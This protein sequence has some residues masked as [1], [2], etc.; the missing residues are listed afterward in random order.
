MPPRVVLVEEAE[1]C[2]G[3]IMDPASQR[4]SDESRLY[5]ERAPAQHASVS[6]TAYGAERSHAVDYGEP[7]TD[8]YVD[9]DP[10]YTQSQSGRPCPEAVWGHRTAM[11]RSAPAP[12]AVIA[13]ARP[14][15]T[16]PGEE[17][18]IRG[19]TR[20]P[21]PLDAPDVALRGQRQLAYGERLRREET[22]PVN[23]AAGRGR[24]S[25]F[26]FSRIFSSSRKSFVLNLEF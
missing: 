2:D 23:H 25:S 24:G 3:R 10:W 4:A 7:E 15:L 6:A 21:V 14:V 8:Y 17:D 5:R 26:G 16:A 13:P 22:E 9:R 19:A 11:P 20:H 18:R 1:C 12:N